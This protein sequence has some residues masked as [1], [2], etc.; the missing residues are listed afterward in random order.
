MIEYETLLMLVLGVLLGSI[1]GTEYAGWRLSRRLTNTFLTLIGESP[2]FWATLNPIEKT[3][4][5]GVKLKDLFNTMF[6]EVQMPTP[7]PS[8]VVGIRG[9]AFFVPQ[10]PSC[11]YAAPPI[12]Q[13]AGGSRVE[14]Y[15]PRHGSFKVTVPVPEEKEK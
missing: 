10:C 13:P 5:I 4:L 6:P 11:G 9:N 1:I 12:L 7:R 14:G 3:R 8:R 15:C 2:K